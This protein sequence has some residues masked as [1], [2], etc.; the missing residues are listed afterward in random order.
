MGIEVAMDYALQ[1]APDHPYVKDFPRWFKW[2]PDGTVQY[3][4][5]PPKNTKI[6]NRFILKVAIGKTYGKNC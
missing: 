1:A 3:A 4:E 6:F 2:R 5:N